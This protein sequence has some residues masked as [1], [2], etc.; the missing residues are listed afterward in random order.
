MSLCWNVTVQSQG[1]NVTSGS[2]ALYIPVIIY[3]NSIIC[4]ISMPCTVFCFFLFSNYFV[5]Y[6]YKLVTNKILIPHAERILWQIPVYNPE[7]LDT[8]Q[9]Y[10]Y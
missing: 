4:I 6:F 8:E 7:M 1:K 9:G 5:F 2:F 3:V 10:A